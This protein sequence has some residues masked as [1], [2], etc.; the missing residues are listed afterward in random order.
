VALGLT[1]C[2]DDNG[3][4]DAGTEQPDASTTTE[5]PAPDVTVSAVD[6]A[7]ELLPRTLPVGTTVALRNLS[8]TELHEFTAYRLPDGETRTASTILQL[9]ASEQ[10]AFFAAP[11]AMLLLGPPGGAEQIAALGDGTFTTPG[12]YLVL[13]G[14]PIG[15]DPQGYLTAAAASGGGRPAVPGGAPH[16]TRGMFTDV[17]VA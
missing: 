15:A 5:A 4:D 1:A 16:Y 8:P 10:A 14:I 7:Y 2:S 3:S 11:P 12:R 13:C 6:Y 17:N 9:P